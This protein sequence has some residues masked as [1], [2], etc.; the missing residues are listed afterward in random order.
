MHRVDLRSRFE[1][2]GPNREA[3]VR[4]Y[5]E[6]LVDKKIDA[7]L[8][9]AQEELMHVR[10]GFDG[11]QGAFLEALNLG[12]PGFRE[13]AAYRAPLRRVSLPLVGSGARSR[14]AGLDQRLPAVCA[15][16][17]A[18]GGSGRRA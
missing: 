18:S 13:V 15:R 14:A 6:W 5:V 16:L 2:S 10:E 4:N 7:V 17:V 8:F 11:P 3:T 12:R 9:P 1:L